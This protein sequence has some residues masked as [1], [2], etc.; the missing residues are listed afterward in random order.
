MKTRNMSWLGLVAFLAV[1]VYAADSA[2][3]AAPEVATGTVAQASMAPVAPP[4]GLSPTAAEVVKL[5]SAGMGDEVILAYV[6]SSQ[7][8]F[9]LSA[10]AILKLKELGVSSPVIAAMLTHDGSQRNRTVPPAYASGQQPP[11]PAPAPAPAADQPAPPQTPGPDVVAPPPGMTPPPTPV[12]VVT[13]APG[14][15]YY[16]VPGYWGWN[17]GWVWIGGGWGYG[18]GG[19]YGRGGW[20]RRCKGCRWGPPLPSMARAS[21]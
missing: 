10:S 17:G 5:S 13:V 12:E 3:P 4:T 18:W 6:K 21:P 1:P 7:A 2:T 20:R 8:P 9:N 15:D 19:W 16:W 14:P 11:P